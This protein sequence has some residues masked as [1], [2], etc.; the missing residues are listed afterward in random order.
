MPPRKSATKASRQSRVSEVPQ[1]AG[2]SS[3]TTL[4]VIPGPSIPESITPDYQPSERE[5]IKLD[6]E[7]RE[8]FLHDLV[9]F[10]P[11]EVC[12][13][14]TE[15]VLEVPVLITNTLQH[16]AEQKYR[17]RDGDPN[18]LEREMNMGLV[19]IETLLES[20][21]DKAMDKFTAWALRNTFD[22]PP[23]VEVVLPWQE[24]LDFDRAA[25]VVQTNGLD[26]LT[27][28]LEGSRTKLEQARLL[29][30]RL[31][32][33]EQALDRKT[34]ILKQRQAEVGFV[35]QVLASSGLSPLPEKT[36]QIVKFLS[37]LHDTLQPLTDEP[38]QSK[39]QPTGS[40]TKAWEMGRQAYLQWAVNRVTSDDKASLSKSTTNLGASTMSVRDGGG[41][42]SVDSVSEMM[43]R[44]DQE[45]L[46][47]LTRAMDQ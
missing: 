4:P 22:I 18:K 7:D 20:H 15:R 39:A 45:G 2:E 5:R 27:E 14:F 42:G 9:C 24:G 23:N 21:V 28:S 19:A 26:S 12:D 10:H 16:W 25:H 34:E 36:E 47:K 6:E 17:Q 32:L 38:L 44:S 40:N 30:Q 41:G 11:R 31:I 43:Q 3:R 33:A 1:K 29:A 13:Q 37:S 35:K 46:E 8:A